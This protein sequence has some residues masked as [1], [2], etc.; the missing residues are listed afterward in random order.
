KPPAG[1]AFRCQSK[2]QAYWVN[3]QVT[4][5]PAYGGITLPF[6]IGAVVEGVPTTFQTPLSGH[7]CPV[8]AVVPIGALDML[9]PLFVF[10]PYCCLC[11]DTDV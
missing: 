5:F 2:Y 10:C 9:I 1:A 11:S 8:E 4:A 7:F 6:A 3:I